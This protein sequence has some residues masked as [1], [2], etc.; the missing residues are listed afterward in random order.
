M[1]GPT[2]HVWSFSSF[3]KQYPRVCTACQ[4]DWFLPRGAHES[5][6][7]SG[8]ADERRLSLPSLV[9]HTERSPIVKKTKWKMSQKCLYKDIFLYY[10]GT[11]PACQQ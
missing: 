7:L 10:M 11:L 6:G 9:S 8:D 2:F 4:I 5:D 3:S 1:L